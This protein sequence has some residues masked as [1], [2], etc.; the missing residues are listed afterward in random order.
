MDI[1]LHKKRWWRR[2]YI[3]DC[4]QFSVN[5]N[6]HCELFVAETLWIDITLNNS[7]VVIAVVYRHP[8]SGAGDMDRFNDSM[9]KMLDTVNKKKRPF[10]NL[11]EIL[12]LTN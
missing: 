8:G 10:Y 1:N 11:W 9:Q 12:T 5:K 6:V 7:S 3:K 4:F 2:L